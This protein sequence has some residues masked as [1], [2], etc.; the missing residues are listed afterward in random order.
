MT[1]L[2][3]GNFF[4]DYYSHRFGLEFKLGFGLGLELGLG[5]RL[6]L[7]VRFF[8]LNYEMYASTERAPRLFLKKNGCKFPM[9]RTEGAEIILQF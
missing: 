1:S 4:F 9:K 6:V 8:S 3:F 5:L 7:W 2:V